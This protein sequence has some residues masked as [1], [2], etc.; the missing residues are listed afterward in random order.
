MVT[1]KLVVL[2]R[3]LPIYLDSPES[4]GFVVMVPVTAS[5]TYLLAVFSF[6][7]DGDLGARQ[8]MYPARRFTRPLTTAALAGL[9]MLYG[10]AAVIILWVGSRLF[11]LWP[12]GRPAPWLWPALLP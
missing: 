4:F 1:I 2:A 11:A 8:A 9:P 7:L 5:F 6:G 12:T 10:S 3:G